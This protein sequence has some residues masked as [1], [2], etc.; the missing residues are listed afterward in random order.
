M[1]EIKRAPA[2]DASGNPIQRPLV[3]RRILV[4]DD[5]ADIRQ[6][7]SEVLIGHGYQ[8]DAVESGVAAWRSL[9][10]KNYDLLVTDNNMEN[11]SGVEL[12]TKLHAARKALPTIMATGRPP[13]ELTDYPWLQPTALLIKPF[14]TEEF[15]EKVQEVLRGSD[16]IQFI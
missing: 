1:I 2:S 14:T 15:L 6:L 7:N 5:D 13:R 9:L 10:A 12:L 8:V 11:G 3:P 4:V 16:D